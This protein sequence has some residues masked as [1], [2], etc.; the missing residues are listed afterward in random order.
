MVFRLDRVL[1]G[2]VL[3]NFSSMVFN[4]FSLMVFRLESMVNC[5]FMEVHWL[6][7]MLI[8]VLVIKFMVN[9][10]ILVFTLLVL[11]ANSVL[12]I[13]G[14]SFMMEIRFKSVVC[15]WV[16]IYDLWSFV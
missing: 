16:M 15:S 1:W 13:K 7:V 11:V 9:L 10:V 4:N 14:L 3:N 5:V 8:I 6:N 2:V 12:M